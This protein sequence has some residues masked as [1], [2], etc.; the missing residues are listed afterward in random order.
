MHICTPIKNIVYDM[1]KYIQRTYYDYFKKIIDKIHVLPEF[2]KYAAYI[3][4]DRRENTISSLFA[5]RIS[6]GMIYKIVKNN[7]LVD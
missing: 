1:E 4:H 5:Y 6:I 3:I 7:Q 2:K